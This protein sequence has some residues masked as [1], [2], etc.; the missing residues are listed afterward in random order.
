MSSSIDSSSSFAIFDPSS[1]CSS[2]D[3]SSPKSFS[4]SLLVVWLCVA[5]VGAPSSSFVL[6]WLLRVL[7]FAHADFDLANSWAGLLE[8]SSCL[9]QKPKNFILCIKIAIAHD[10]AEDSRQDPEFSPPDSFRIKRVEN[11][12]FN[13][14]KELFL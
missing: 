8:T 2:L 7:V 11:A 5:G 10:I 3:R 4:F 12:F 14:F 6:V 1:S 13:S 9:R